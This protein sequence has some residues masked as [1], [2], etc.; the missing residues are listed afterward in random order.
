VHGAFTFAQTHPHL[1]KEWLHI[2]NYIC[3]LEI[4]NEVELVKLWEKSKQENI[5]GACFIEP[6]FDNSL[7]AI[8]LGPGTE[9]KKLCSHL[10]LA[11]K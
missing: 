10:K 8:A 5:P 3:I 1:T 6:D 9:S 4:D 11:L 7:T 2:S